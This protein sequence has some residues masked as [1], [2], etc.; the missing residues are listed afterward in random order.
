MPDCYNQTQPMAGA[1][2]SPVLTNKR[3]AWNRIN[4]TAI[5]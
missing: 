3:T 4:T 2:E 5:S 1:G